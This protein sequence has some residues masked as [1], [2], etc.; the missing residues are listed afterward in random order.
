[1]FLDFC[2]CFC[3]S[4]VLNIMLKLCHAFSQYSVNIL[5]T[6]Y[7]WHYNCNVCTV[8]SNFAHV[9]TELFVVQ[10]G[11]KISVNI[12]FQTFSQILPNVVVDFT[13]TILTH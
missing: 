6:T 13:W 4:L 2:C 10:F 3:F 12:N 8:S 9:R 11:W 1:M 7:G 5:L